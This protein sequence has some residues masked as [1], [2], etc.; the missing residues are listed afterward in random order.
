MSDTTLNRFVASGTA[1]QRVAFTPAPATPASGPSPLCIWYETDTGDTYISANAAAWVLVTGNA[2]DVLPWKRPCRAKTTAALAANTYANGT[3]GVGA[4]LTA[5]ANGALAAQ[6]GITL[7]AGE[8]LLVAN[9][10]A[11]ANNGIYTVTQVGTGGTPYI[12]TR[13]TDA[14]NGTG[15]VNATTTIS[16]GTVA[17]DLTYQCT[18]NAAITVGTTA[19]VW[20]QATTF[21][22]AA[23]IKAG[24]NATKPIASDQLSAAAAPQTLTDAAPTA[25]DMS[26]GYNAKWTLGASRT[27]STPTNPTAGWTY[28]LGVI[29]DGTG[30]RLVTWPAS[31]DW[32]TTGAPTLTTTASKVDRVTLF[33]TDAATPKFEA[34]LSAKGFAS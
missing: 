20:A 23:E 28:S 15:L 4:T 10:A 24:T 16:E 21:A 8:R 3:S 13:A 5:N 12:L 31:F 18:T 34:F 29:Q 27:L 33:C 7:V 11:G 19:Q 9:E 14:N 25:W 6:D 1:A 32:G 30:S 22:S 2:L 26:L 17:A